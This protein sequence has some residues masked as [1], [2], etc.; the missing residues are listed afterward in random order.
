MA[1]VIDASEEVNFSPWKLFTAGLQ[2][3]SGYSQ[4]L[5]SLIQDTGKLYNRTRD[6]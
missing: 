3:D 5:I 2:Y 4:L 1:A 6:P